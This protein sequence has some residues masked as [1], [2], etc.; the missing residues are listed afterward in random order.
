[1][2]RP[3]SRR[4]SQQRAK[5]PTFIFGTRKLRSE[6]QRDSASERAE[7]DKLVSAY[8]RGRGREA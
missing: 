3:I 4:K 1:M 7:K 2:P 5:S 6:P 8:M